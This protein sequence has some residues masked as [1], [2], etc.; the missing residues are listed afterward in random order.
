MW[1]VGPA[2]HADRLAGRALREAGADYVLR[3]GAPRP[4]AGFLPLPG[5]GPVM[6]W[7]AVT[8]A[9]MPPLSNWLLG[10]GDIELF[11]K[12]IKETKQGKA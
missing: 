11:F 1:S 10:L 3:L 8:D 4:G 9:G 12:Q 5:A 7:R 6:T 2:E